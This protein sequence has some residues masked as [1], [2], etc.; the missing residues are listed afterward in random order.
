MPRFEVLI[1]ASP[2]EQ[3]FH[4]TLRV[5]SET[6]LPAL[7]VGLQKICGAEL[8]PNILCDVGDD[9]AIDVTDPVSGR[10]FRITEVAPPAAPAPASASASAEAKRARA[11]AK[12]P[13]ASARRIG[14]TPPELRRE[15]LLADLFLRSPLVMERRTRD[16]GL[17]YLL[18]LALEKVPSASGAVLLASAEGVLRFVVA[19]GDRATD[20][21]KRGVE[22]PLGVGILGFCAQEAVGLAVS[23]PEHHPLFDRVVSDAVR[24]TPRSLLAVPIADGAR[25]H[26]CLQLVDRSGGAYD[27]GDVAAL[28]Y[29]AH[30]AA[31]F[32]A[33]R[34]AREPT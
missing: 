10:V 29:L 24:S 7:K 17:G 31:Q 20:A 18:D 25:V 22:V 11:E 21:L 19:R 14:R 6:W 26:G 8:T 33:D 34:A 5:E 27:E 12:A 32:L 30:R 15:E 13:V 23:D 4:V 9:G 2:P 3:P 28:S 1:P 16:E